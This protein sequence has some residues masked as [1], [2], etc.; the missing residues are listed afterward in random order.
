MKISSLD[1]AHAAGVSPATVSLVLNGRTHIALSPATR[2]RVRE[3]AE[4]L[5]YRPNHLARSLHRGKSQ[6][7]GVVLPSL[8]SSYVAR[9]AEGI[10]TEAGLSDHRMLLAHTRHD[11]QV[12]IQQFELLLQHKVEG[13]VIVTG[14]TTLPM[15][16]D[17]LA[18]LGRAQVPCVVVDDR[19][20][21]DR[22]DCVVS[23]DRLGAELAVLHLVAG[24]HRRIAHL[25]AGTFTST[26]R[27]RLAGYQ[28][29]LR[30]AK[31]PFSQALVL[32]NS[33]LGGES[34]A[35]LEQLLA[36][37]NPPTAIFAANDRRLA[38]LLPLFRSRALRVPAALALVGYANYDFAEYLDLTSVDQHPTELGRAAFRRLLARI[39]KPRMEPKL[40]ELPI[41]LVPRGSSA[42]RNSSP[43][44]NNIS[45]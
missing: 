32:G 43:R 1:V 5:G 23:D 28:A 42:N 18:V 30:K 31:L 8:A 7:I 45:S 14:E 21:A 38:E 20:H 36:S 3:A 35:A 10:Q 33:Y 37:S 6:T 11:P 34:T 17:R 25:A 9:I 40:I 12:E 39:A 44:P 2:Q 24:G 41:R 16:A 4:R 29:A 26:A 13:I 19:T 22:V 15:L 27:D